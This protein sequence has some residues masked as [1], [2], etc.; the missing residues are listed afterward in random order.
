[1]SPLLAAFF[2]AA[3]NALNFIVRVPRGDAGYQKATGSMES[4]VQTR[5]NMGA[6]G[7]VRFAKR[8][9]ARNQAGR[10]DKSEVEGGG[11]DLGKN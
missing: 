11:R 9:N 3:V 4:A 8:R 5:W 6:G 10:E 2:S 7:E 1:M